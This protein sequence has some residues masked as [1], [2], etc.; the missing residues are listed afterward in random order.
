MKKVNFYGL[1][2]DQ[3]GV[4]DAVQRLGCVEIVNSDILSRVGALDAEFFEPLNCEKRKNIKKSLAVIDDSIDVVKKAMESISGE[5]EEEDQKKFNKISPLEGLMNLSARNFEILSKKAENIIRL[6][7]DTV[8]DAKIIKDKEDR[9]LK[10]KT[11]KEELEYWKEL[12][13]PTNTKG[14]KKTAC[15]IGTLP[16]LFVDVRAILGALSDDLGKCKDYL[17]V[18]VLR[19]TEDFAYIFV[20]CRKDDLD[21]FLKEFL[22]LG[23]ISCMFSDSTV[24][25]DEMEYIDIKV[26][27][28][29]RELKILKNNM[30]NRRFFLKDLKFCY[31]YYLSKREKYEAIAKAENTSKTFVLTGYTPFKCVK[32]IE[33]ELKKYKNIFYEIEDVNSEDE[34]PVAL[35]NRSACAAVEPVLESYSLPS[36]YES[37]PTSVMSVFYYFLFGLM[38]SDAGYGA[39]MSLVCGGLLLKFKNMKISLK[40]SLTMFFIC[41]I[42]TFF[43]GLMFGSF[44]GD[45][46]E[47]ISSTF[48]G[49]RV[50]TPTFWFVPIKNP[51]F[52]L[53]FSFGVGIVHMFTGLTLKLVQLLRMRKYKEA[54]Y[55]VVSWFFLVGGLVVFLLSVP[56]VPKL[57][58]LDLK[59]PIFVANVSKI[60]ML[61]GAMVILF[62]SGRGSSNIFKRLLKGVYGL[63]GVTNYLSD[64]ISY[65]R[66]LALG[67]STGVIAQVFNK[68]GA[69]GGNT[70]FGVILFLSV[71]FVG[72]TVN[73][74]INL[75]GAYVH[76][77]RLQFVEFFSKFYEGGG[78]KFSPFTFKTKYY[79][80]FGGAF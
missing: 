60:C 6:A 19:V 78:R 32:K 61:L 18:E 27:R 52:M 20:L 29:E 16:S 59:V 54:V 37:D 38:L 21:I 49:H 22:N 56:I 5:L 24:P 17:H 50:S 25:A 57:L 44:F 74:L 11:M 45:A 1:E 15:F 66:L 72:H 62:T 70:T 9:L 71:F 80:F 76:T 68:M 77:N 40:R 65:S 69:M 46:I 31:D 75:L 64:I 73:I 13:I 33:K 8:G 42:S 14:T 79:N 53:S 28:I 51:M 55:D 23:F 47:V 35:K 63:Y 2:K 7:Y 10:L 67:L 26:S 34:V 12:D 30:R 43:W 3:I 41:G 39:I 4:L 58:S 36:K 48:L